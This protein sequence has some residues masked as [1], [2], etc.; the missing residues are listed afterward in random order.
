[1]PSQPYTLSPAAPVTRPFSSALRHRPQVFGVLVG[2]FVV[3]VIVLAVRRRRAV[4]IAKASRRRSV[5][6]GGT[7]QA[8]SGVNPMHA[9]LVDKANEQEADLI[10]T[11]LW[12]TM[13]CM[14]LFM[15]AIGLTVPVYPEVL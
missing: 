7:T 14:F 3:L 10:R 8:I 4:R 12:H 15:F 2:V 9:D 11:P 6:M 5:N 13:V 1:M